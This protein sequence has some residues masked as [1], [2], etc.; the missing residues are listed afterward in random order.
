MAGHVQPRRKLLRRIAEL[1]AGPEAAVVARRMEEF[2]KARDSPRSLFGELCFCIL[3]ANYTAEGGMRIQKALG[4]SFHR[5]T[6]RELASRLRALGHRFPNMRANFIA[7]AQAGRKELAAKL[8][9]CSSHS[10]REWLAQNVYG[11][12]YKEAS[13]FLRNVGAT[14]VAIVDFHIIDLLS[15]YRIIRKSGAKTKTLSRKRYLAIERA[16]ASLA[17]DAGLTLAELDLYLWFMET[18]KIL[19]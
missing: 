9:A 15:R 16:L 6:E 10:M 13:H 12:G 2:R 19:K 18:G 4:G 14:D 8:N 7:R 11:I 5:L 3:T 17:S 1:K